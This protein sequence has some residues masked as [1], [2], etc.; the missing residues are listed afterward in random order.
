MPAPGRPLIYVNAGFER[1]T[2]YAAAEAI[3]RNCRFLQGPDTDPETTA[4]HPPRAPRRAP[5]TVQVLNYRKGGKQFWNRL[6]ITPL[7]DGEGRVTHFIGVQSDVTA[8]A[9][10]RT[11]APG[12]SRAGRGE[13]EDA[14]DLEAAA[15]SS[16]RCCRPSCPGFPGSS[17]PL[18]S[19]PAPSWRGTTST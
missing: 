11:V 18:P 13:P 10:P 9:G 2:G 8:G 14:A 7:R 3:G 4:D 17:L 5:V 12:Q 6:S 19:R 15:G 16:A 1:L